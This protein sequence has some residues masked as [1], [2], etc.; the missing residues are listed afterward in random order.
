MLYFYTVTMR[1][2]DGTLEQTVLEA[3]DDNHARTE[4]IADLGGDGMATLVSVER[5]E[6]T[7]Y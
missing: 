3:A 5:G 4:A 6:L 7:G 2:A 1:L